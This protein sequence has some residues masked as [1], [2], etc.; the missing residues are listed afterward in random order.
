MIAIDDDNLSMM[1][2]NVKGILMIQKRN[3][4]IDYLRKNINTNG[5]VFFT[6][7]SLLFQRRKKWE[8][9]FQGQ[10]FFSH[11]KTN[12]CGVAIG[13]YG[14]KKLS[15]LN[16]LKDIN[17][18]ILILEVNIDGEVYVLANYYNNNIESDQMQTLSELD[19][20]LNKIPD[21][22]TKKIILGGDF[23]LFFN[24]LTEAEGGN[25]VLK[26]R[27]V[28]KSIEILEKFDLCD[29]W[30][31]RNP[32]TKR[33]TFRQKHFSGLIQRR[34]DYFFV[35]NLLQESVK[36]TDILASLSSDHSPILISL[37]KCINPSRG[38]GLWKFNCSLLKNANFVEK[39]KNH[40]SVSEMGTFKIRNE[41]IF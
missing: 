3:K 12:S 17:G 32:K 24:S 31:I 11:G 27:S 5:L 33:F 22:L 39:M 10:L 40:I 18:R 14:K 35:S 34:L 23:N 28:A 36:H 1:S 8:D 9:Q 25:P 6:R 20:L 30:R 37:M 29:I 26:K 19:N 2:F 15:L 4:K 13:Y 16:E 38:R 21:I 7:N 41:K